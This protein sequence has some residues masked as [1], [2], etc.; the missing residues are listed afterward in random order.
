MGIGAHI[1]YKIHE[2]LNVSDFE[3]PDLINTIEKTITDA[4]K[5]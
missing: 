3:T 5:I 2:P 1:K 4:I